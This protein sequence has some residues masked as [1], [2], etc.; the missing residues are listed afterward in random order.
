MPS[1]LV[2]ELSA[3]HLNGHE[4]ANAIWGSPVSVVSDADDIRALR[5]SSRHWTIPSVYVGRRLWCVRW[6]SAPICKPC[7]FV[8]VIRDRNRPVQNPDIATAAITVATAERE[9]PVL[10]LDRRIAGKFAPIHAMTPMKPHL[11]ASTAKALTTSSEKSHIRP[12]PQEKAHHHC[13][14]VIL[15]MPN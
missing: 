12:H 1:L 2:V 4:T 7:K 10:L 15:F 5:T 8:V 11:I 6:L 9:I 13:A 14:P 3:K